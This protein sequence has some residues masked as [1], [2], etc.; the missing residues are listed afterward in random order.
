MSDDLYFVE[1]MLLRNCK[2]LG[3]GSHSRAFCLVD[4]RDL[5]TIKK[6]ELSHDPEYAWLYYAAKLRDKIHDLKTQ[7]K[8]TEE[9]IE[10]CESRGRDA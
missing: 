10:I 4:G 2:V 8:N 5:K 1:D 9:N 3:G 7:I 6:N